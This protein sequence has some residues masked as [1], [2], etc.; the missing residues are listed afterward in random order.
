MV[1]AVGLLVA[2]AGATVWLGATDAPA[3][4]PLVENPGGIIVGLI[5]GAVSLTA[6][7]IPRLNNI[8]DATAATQ[9]HVVN[10]HGDRVLRDDLDRAI[11]LMEGVAKQVSQIRRTQTDHGRDIGGIRAD[12]RQL[13]DVDRDNG[14]DIAEVRRTVADLDHKLDEHIEHPHKTPPKETP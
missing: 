7:I 10:D 3:G 13:R 1:F 12:V 8:R 2:A 5:G 9:H 6:L 11:Q 4:R 14:R